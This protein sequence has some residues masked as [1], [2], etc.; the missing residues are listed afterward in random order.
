[1]AWDWSKIIG[2]DSEVPHLP[3]CKGQIGERLS[4]PLKPFSPQQRERRRAR[5]KRE[6]QARATMYRVRKRNKR[7]F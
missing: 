4:N 3:H 5:L 6:R 7:R 1:M 2:G